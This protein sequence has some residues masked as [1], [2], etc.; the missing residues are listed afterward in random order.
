MRHGKRFSVYTETKSESN[1]MCSLQDYVLV[2]DCLC[3]QELSLAGG[4][5]ANDVDFGT[6][7]PPQYVLTSS[8]GQPFVV[9]L[10]GKAKMRPYS[11]VR[12]VGYEQHNGVLGWP[13]TAFP[14]YGTS[15]LL[16]VRLASPVEYVFLE[17]DWNH[18][19]VIILSLPATGS[20]FL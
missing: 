9:V 20:I 8:F 2:P 14:S 12:I 5:F 11:G 13:V 19:G 16:P 17:D 3:F 10:C 1:W 15:G 4:K 7:K 6:W 18:R